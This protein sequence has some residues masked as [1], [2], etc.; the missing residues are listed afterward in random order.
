[1]VG[2]EIDEILGAQGVSEPESNSERLDNG[3]ELFAPSGM[4]AHGAYEEDGPVTW[5]TL[6]HP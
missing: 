6:T 1:M 3:R 5:E 2:P 4:F